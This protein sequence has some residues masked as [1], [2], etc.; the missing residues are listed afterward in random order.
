MLVFW[1]VNLLESKEVISDDGEHG[2]KGIVSVL[3]SK[4]KTVK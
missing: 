2:V 4:G 1:M 3:D